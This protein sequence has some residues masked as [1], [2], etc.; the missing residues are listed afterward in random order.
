MKKKVFITTTAVASLMF[1]AT[2]YAADAPTD[3][4]STLCKPKFYAGADDFV[5]FTADPADVSKPSGYL[6]PHASPSLAYAGFP[7]TQI[8]R[9][10]NSY[11]VTVA[12]PINKVITATLSAKI[13]ASIKPSKSGAGFVDVVCNK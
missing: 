3:L 8:V 4:T 6:K 12:G 11:G 9:T 7:V 5:T 13:S 10:A 1:A 2:A